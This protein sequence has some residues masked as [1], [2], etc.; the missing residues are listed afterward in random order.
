MNEEEFARCFEDATWHCE[1][2][3]HGDLNYVGKFALSEL[4]RENGYKVVLTGEGADEQ[5]A[6]YPMYLPDFVRERDHAWPSSELPENVRSNRCK[7]ANTEIGEY[8]ESIEADGSNRRT[9]EASQMLGGTS[10]PA[11]MCVFH[12]DSF[13]PWTRE[14][15]IRDPRMT[16]A[17]GIASNTRKRMQTTWHPLHSALYTWSKGQLVSNFLS[18]L[19]E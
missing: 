4:A 19:G 13:A 17:Q 16:I 8:Y 15:Y 1:Q 10:T 14:L 7:S 3:N 5:F 6:G 11:S 12:F 9:D 18:C 2:H